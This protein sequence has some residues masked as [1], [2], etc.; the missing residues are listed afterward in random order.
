[1]AGSAIN[2]IFKRMDMAKVIG[3]AILTPKRDELNLLDNNEIKKFFEK[4]IQQWSL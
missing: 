2:K 4:K 3:G 1:M